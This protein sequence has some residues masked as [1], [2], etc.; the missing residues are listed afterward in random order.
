MGVR[1]ALDADPLI[2]IARRGL[3]GAVGILV[4]FVIGLALMLS[5]SRPLSDLAEATQRLALGE[6]ATRVEVS[7]GDEI[8]Q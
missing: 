1:R 4:A 6:M 8:G 7:S 5:I 3:L 2:D